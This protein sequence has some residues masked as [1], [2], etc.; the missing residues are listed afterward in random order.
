MSAV[1]IVGDGQ[2]ADCAG[3]NLAGECAVIRLTGFEEGVPLEADLILLL[4]DEWRP[5]EYEEAERTLRQAGVPWIGGYVAFDKGVVGP[6]VTPGKPGCSQCAD[7]RRLAAGHDFGDNREPLMSLFAHGVVPRDPAASDWGILQM[8]FLVAREARNVL[9]GAPAR[10]DEAVYRIDLK[11][12]ESTRHRFLP[13]P[14]CPYCGGLPEDSPEGA[15][16]EMQPRPK[17]DADS[18]RVR[19]LGRELTDALAADYLDERT[20]ILRGKYL[21]LDST[22][23]N[24][25][26]WQPT[27]TGPEWSGGR[28]HSYEQSGY[29]A[30]LEGLERYCSLTARGKRTAVAGS[31]RQFADRALDPRKAGLYEAEQYEQPDFPYEP[32]D[33]DLVLNWVWGYSFG[34]GRPI[35]VPEQLAYYTASGGESFV[36]ESSNGCALGSSLEEAIFHGILE[37]AERDSFLMTWYARLPIP[38]LDP[39]SAGDPELSHMVNRLRAT[40]GYETLLFNAT[41]E[42]RIPAVVAVLRNTRPTGANLVCSAGAHPDPVR[43][44]KGAICEA[45]GHVGYLSERLKRERDEI[46][47]MLDD[48]SLVGTMEDHAALYSH[49]QA[50][51]RFAFLLKSSA[52][53]RAF[54]EQFERRK[55]SADLTDDL[56]S[57]I[58][59]FRELGLDVIVVDQTAPEIARIGLHVV[60]VLIPGL[61]PM[62]FGHQLRRL[63]GLERLYRI[64]TVLGFAKQPLTAGRLN[65]YPHPFF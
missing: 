47:L 61:L 29:T 1:A 40:E 39:E 56:K 9:T 15:R 22:F 65:P 54:G 59:V 8:G 62:T 33:D 64:P 42:N 35:L 51:E 41:T 45:A 7:A 26:F 36:M 23:A 32:F 28:G 43:A 58:A 38:R 11:T 19:P 44:A 5:E 48:P 13:N 2:L 4:K 37:A 63:N 49:P 3:E 55:R 16:I 6:L 60:K 25:S 18:Y 21:D 24:V 46:A 12:L 34:K 14:Q 30:M 57:T 27:L 10:T 52:P 17:L 50:E 20:G 31:Y 53:P